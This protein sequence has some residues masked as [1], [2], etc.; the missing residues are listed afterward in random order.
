MPY[1]NDNAG[2]R[3]RGVRGGPTV[4]RPG[5]LPRY[6]AAESCDLS[7]M[8]TSQLV[9]MGAAG[10]GELA[11]RGRGPSGIK[12]NLPEWVQKLRDERAPRTSRS[13][14]A[15]KPNVAYLRQVAAR[16]EHLMRSGQAGDL[17][18]AW[19]MAKHQR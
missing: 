15:P 11:R 5:R 7:A 4:Q 10:I 13:N 3:M 17:I 19:R 14:P 8:T 1:S 12:L 2:R 9:D 18:S 6:P 16:A